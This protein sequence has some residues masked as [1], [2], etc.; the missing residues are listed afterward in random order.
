MKFRFQAKSL[1]TLAVTALFGYVVFEAVQKPIQASLFP[2]SVGIIALVLLAVLLVRELRQPA[3]DASQDETGSTVDFAIT[4]EEETREGRLRALEQF[5]WLF[6][7][8]ISLWL[9]GY[10]MA[11]PAF[12]AAYM[13]RYGENLMITAVS[14]GG[15]LLAV[16]SVFYKLL[17]LPF[18]KGEL[19]NWLGLW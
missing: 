17:H 3:A 14:A 19:I 11:V 10:F 6:G 7:L 8:V 9:F 1:F 16:W 13:L 2:L 5:G 12:V 15:I 18:P 4:A